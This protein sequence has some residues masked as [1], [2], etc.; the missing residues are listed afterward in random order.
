MKGEDAELDL[1]PKYL[2]DIPVGAGVWEKVPP[3]GCWPEHHRGQLS[4]LTQHPLSW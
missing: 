4:A 2:W 3:S 1:N